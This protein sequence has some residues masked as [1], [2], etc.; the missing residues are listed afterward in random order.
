MAY[1]VEKVENRPPLSS[2]GNHFE[3]VIAWRNISATSG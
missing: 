3:R 2:D 1:F